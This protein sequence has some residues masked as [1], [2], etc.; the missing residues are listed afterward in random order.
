MTRLIFWFLVTILSAWGA[1]ELCAHFE[2]STPFIVISACGVGWILG[3]KMGDAVN[4][5]TETYHD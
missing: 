1:A 3:S 2:A 5:W 4:A